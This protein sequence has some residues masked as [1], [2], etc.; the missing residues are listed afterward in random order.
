MKKLKQNSFYFIIGIALV[1]FCLSI[2]SV[3]VET[4]QENNINKNIEFLK[5]TNT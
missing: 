1:L 5:Q 2:N 3:G 4:S